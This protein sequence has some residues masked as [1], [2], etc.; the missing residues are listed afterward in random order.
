MNNY[1]LRYTLHYYE[2]KE[3]EKKYLICFHTVA[4][5]AR[6]GFQDGGENY[7][8]GPTLNVTNTDWIPF[9]HR[10]IM[11]FGISVASSI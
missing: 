6:R 11:L 2:K 1:E 7:G 10:N 4:I 3:K 8:L 5:P 9:A